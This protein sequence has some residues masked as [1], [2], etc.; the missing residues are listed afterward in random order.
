MRK[1]FSDVPNAKAS[2]NRSKANQIFSKI[3]NLVHQAK[4]KRKYTKIASNSLKTIHQQLETIS[5]GSSTKFA[6]NP[7]YMQGKKRLYVQSKQH[8]EELDLINLIKII[9]NNEPNK[10]NFITP[11]MMKSKLTQKI[12]QSRKRSFGSTSQNFMRAEHDHSVNYEGLDRRQ[13]K[14]LRKV[15]N[16][17][18]CAGSPFAQNEKKGLEA[19]GQGL[20]FSLSPAFGSSVQG[21]FDLVDLNRDYCQVVKKEDI[22]N[23]MKKVR[24]SRLI[25]LRGVFKA[26]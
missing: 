4:I 8:D 3:N 14:I 24:L 13:S 23:G 5:L 11:D 7:F 6:D 17:N 9:D 18:S 12:L 25:S 19:S 16:V 26:S 1:S 21:S 22:E 2:Q 20:R 10:K 15:L